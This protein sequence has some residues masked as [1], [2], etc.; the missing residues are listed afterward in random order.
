MHLPNLY[1]LDDD[2][3]M[4]GFDKK[5]CKFCFDLQDFNTVWRYRWSVD[6]NGYVMGSGSGKQIKLH[7]L[8]YLSQ[9]K[10]NLLTMSMGTLRITED[11]I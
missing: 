5:G 9:N 11:I 2:C 3:T 7:R 1:L 4:Y 10:T 8:Y 6:F